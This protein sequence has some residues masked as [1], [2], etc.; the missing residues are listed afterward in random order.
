MKHTIFFIVLS[1]FLAP[2]V[3]PPAT[4]HA[5]SIEY[6]LVDIPDTTAGDDLWQYNY[7]LKGNGNTWFGINDRIHFLFPH[8][9]L[10]PQLPS[11]SIVDLYWVQSINRTL[12]IAR[13]ISLKSNYWLDSDSSFLSVNF[14]R[15]PVPDDSYF[16]QSYSFYQNDI[17]VSEGTT[18]PVPLLPDP[19]PPQVPEPASV[20]LFLT[21]LGLLSRR[22]TRKK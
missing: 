14:I 20:L 21:G 8:Y 2:V 5:L 11:P 10:F 18:T 17:L 4:S 9:V 19:N 12:Y 7:Y 1:L 13:T 3:L 16:N 15:V 6:K 22:V